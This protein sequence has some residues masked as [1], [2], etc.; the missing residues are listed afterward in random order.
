LSTHGVTGYGA[1]TCWQDYRFGMLQV[2]LISTLGFAFSAETERG[3]EMM[4]AMMERG[5]QAIRDLGTLDL[6]RAGV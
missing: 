5:S 3:G 2:P 4:L 1:E 6:V